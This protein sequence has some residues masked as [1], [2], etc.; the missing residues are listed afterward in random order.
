LGGYNATARQTIALNVE[1]A[2]A[3]KNRLRFG[4]PFEVEP[5]SI[6]LVVGLLV[7]GSRAIA[8]TRPRG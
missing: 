1:A 7:F 4:Q 5:A 6:L 8:K 3:I 2:N